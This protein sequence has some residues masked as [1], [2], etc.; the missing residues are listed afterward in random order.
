M[1][2]KNL[3]H[4]C[5]LCGSKSLLLKGNS[6]NRYFCIK[7]IVEFIVSSDTRLVQSV[8]GIGPNGELDEFED[9]REFAIKK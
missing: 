1:A 6:K 9:W 7:C 4:A 5:P 2:V 8:Y 3:S